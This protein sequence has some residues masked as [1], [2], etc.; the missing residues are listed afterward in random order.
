MRVSEEK[1]AKIKASLTATHEK[2]KSQVCKVYALKIDESHLNNQQKEWL[3]R[4]FIEA[5][6]F[7]NHVLSQENIFN[8]LLVKDKKVQVKV[9]DHY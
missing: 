9:L 4:I 1:K 5:K 6:W 7:Y 3:S 2:R 8:P